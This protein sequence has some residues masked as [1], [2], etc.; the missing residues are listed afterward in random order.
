MPYIRYYNGLLQNFSN[1]AFCEMSIEANFR[2]NWRQLI[3]QNL[4][5]DPDSKLGTYLR[6]NPDLKSYIQTP[7]NVIECERILVT[8]FR[9]G[10]HSLAIELGR[11]SNIMRP[12]RLCRCNL[13]VQSV[14][15]VFKD[16]PLTREIH[17][18]QYTKYSAILI[19]ENYF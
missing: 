6:V 16:C 2:L 12:F 9:T 10:F 7:Q 15:H 11:F 19:L 3:N 4:D 17:R 14:L 1:P 8:R 5:N 13:S 18:G